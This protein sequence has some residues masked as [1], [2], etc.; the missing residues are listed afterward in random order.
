MKQI[1]INFHCGQLTL[2]GACYYPDGKGI[3]PAVILCHPHPLYGGSMH[4]SVIMSM[5]ANLVGKSIIA[6][7][8]N[9]RGVGK[10]EGSYAGG[11]GECEDVVAAINWLVPQP[12]VD[13]S[14]L[15]LAGYSFGAS[16]AAPVGCDDERV[17]AIALI[18]PALETSQIT[19]LK[20]CTKPRFII[21]GSED[22]VISREEVE[23]VNGELAEPKRFEIIEGADHFW[24]GYEGLVAEKVTTFFEGIFKGG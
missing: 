18:S 22:D 9:F 10:S 6:F 16:V 21:S 17:K 19:K 8:F 2:E 4:S 12:E 20:D 3:F 24:M 15:G 13:K 11:I 23:L 1:D 14:K 5:G 7:M